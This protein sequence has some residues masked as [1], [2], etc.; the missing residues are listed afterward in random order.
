LISLIFSSKNLRPQA[1]VLSPIKIYRGF[2]VRPRF[3]A[4]PFLLSLKTQE[5]P[6]E[7]SLGKYENTPPTWLGKSPPAR[8]PAPR[9]IDPP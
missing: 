2:Q 1:R 6:D 7:N 3:R 4:T 9:A 8:A 5:D